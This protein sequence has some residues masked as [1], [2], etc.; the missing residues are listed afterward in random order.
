MLDPYLSKSVEIEDPLHQILY[1][2]RVLQDRHAHLR[3]M[4]FDRD[5]Y[6]LMDPAVVTTLGGVS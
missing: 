5:P 3:A 4:P 1:P 2:C 6:Y